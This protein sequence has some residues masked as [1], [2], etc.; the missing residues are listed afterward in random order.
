MEIS[1]QKILT[2][3][4]LCE[5]NLGG[6]EKAYINDAI[7]SNWLSGGSYLSQFE[8]K[9]ADYTGAKH[10]VGLSS[11]TTALHIALLLAGVKPND[12]VLVPDLTFVA[13]ANAVKYTG[14][15]PVLID[16]DPETWLM[17][18]DLLSEFLAN[19]TYIAQGLCFHKN[20]DR[21]IKAIVPV[22]LLGNMC[23]MNQLLQIAEQHHIAVV[24][25]AACS[26][27]SFQNGQ[28]SG[29]FGML[30][31]MSF[32]SNKIITTGGGG[33]ILTNDPVLAAKAK[34]L[35]TQAKSQGTEY[36]HDSLGYNYRLVNPLAAI[37]VAQME[38]LPRFVKVKK[39]VAQYYSENLEGTGAQFQK[40]SQD[41][42]SN[43]W[44]FALL[45]NK[46]RELI[47]F[48]S[49]HYIESRPL[50]VP[51]HKLP[52]F[53]NDLHIHLSNHSNSVSESGIM[54]PCSTSISEDQIIR[55]CNTVKKFLLK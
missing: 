22:H 54:L 52:V 14:A 32:N 25:D 8:Q 1:E 38:L 20:T 31:T 23:D 13:T 37:G 21:L 40:I 30:G 16:I 39:E 44:H 10:V 24:E 36:F 50:W 45:T 19:N 55:V 49:E 2:N 6:N 34:H 7:D 48:L 26:L 17:D 43:C 12:L 3:I 29:T 9:L 46:S 51:I 4:P 28:H 5:P 47:K 42:I 41:T 35:I 33:A 53:K 18:L 27:G 11:G 15:D